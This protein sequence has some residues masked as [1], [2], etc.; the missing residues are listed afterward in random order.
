MI[1]AALMMQSFSRYFVM[2]DYIV[3]QNVYQKACINK[4]KPKLHCNGKCQLVKQLAKTAAGETTSGKELK[5][6]DLELVLSS[7]S[8]FP[9]LNFLEN[10]LKQP[11]FTFDDAL[12]QSFPN[13]I[14]HPPG[15]IS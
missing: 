13:S 4:A 9:K 8:F 5:P 11:Y 3:N 2:A 7:K 12:K 10:R 14:F 6:I 1:F 15:G